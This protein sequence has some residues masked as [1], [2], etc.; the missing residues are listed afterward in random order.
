M[1]A[2]L[3]AGREAATEGSRELDHAIA[4]ELGWTRMEPWILKGEYFLDPEGNEKVVPFWSISI[5]GALTLYKTT[6]ER[7]PSNPLTACIEAL[8]Q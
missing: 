4:G 1:T 6:P 7:I 5:D 8:K 2:D 3:I